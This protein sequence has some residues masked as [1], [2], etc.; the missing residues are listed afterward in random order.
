M[1][2]Y[3][4]TQNMADIDLPALKYRIIKVSLYMKSLHNVLCAAE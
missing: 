3:V 4:Y 2:E 1:L